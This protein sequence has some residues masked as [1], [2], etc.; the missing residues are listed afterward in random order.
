[1]NCWPA[2]WRIGLLLPAALT[3]AIP[4]YFAGEARCA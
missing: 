1:M 2:C 3:W 4:A